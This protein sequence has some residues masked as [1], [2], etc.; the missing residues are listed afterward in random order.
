VE[1]EVLAATNQRA[2]EAYQR[3]VKDGA[4]SSAELRA[5]ALAASKERFNPADPEGLGFGPGDYT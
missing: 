2:V 1:A 3:G 5:T 4:Q